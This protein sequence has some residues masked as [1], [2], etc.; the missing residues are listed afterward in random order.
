MVL[1]LAPIVVFCYWF[2]IHPLGGV[3]NSF[4]AAAADKE[5]LLHHTPSP[6]IVFMGGSNIA[7][8]MDC[9]RVERELNRPT[10]NMGVHA[11]LG[12]DFMLQEAA[13]GIGAGDTFILVPEY[14]QA[15]GKLLYS[16][17]DAWDAL[18]YNPNG[19]R[20][21]SDPDQWG[22]LL[23]SIPELLRE[24]LQRLISRRPRVTRAVGV[25]TRE[26]FDRR[27]DMVAHLTYPQPPALQKPLPITITDFNRD[28]LKLLRR[29]DAQ[30]RSR[31]ARFLFLPP[32]IAQSFWQKS[33]TPIE[34]VAGQ[35]TA[36]GSPKMIAEPRERVLDDSYFF[37]TVY[38]QN[39]RGRREAMDRLM[40]KLR[41]AVLSERRQE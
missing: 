22:Q 1:L 13:S 38:H 12:L 37:D 2:A 17:A 41:D 36:L 25:Y 28:F 39:A 11:G 16:D 5:N 40:P 34:Y 7:F 30:T 27:G 6:K 35:V 24:Q 9:G 8:G 18:Q 31:E 33:S 3:E 26:G 10:I 32:C 23:G 4:Y 29:F 15:F 20:Y 21:M 14:D 19:W